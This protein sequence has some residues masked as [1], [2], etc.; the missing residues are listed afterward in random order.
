MPAATTT[1]AAA[2]TERW[3]RSPRLTTTRF[4]GCA[5]V[6][7]RAVSSPLHSG[8]QTLGCFLRFPC[9]VSAAFPFLRRFFSRAIPF[10]DR[11]APAHFP[12]VRHSSPLLATR[13]LYPSLC[14]L[15]IC[16]TPFF[17]PTDAAAPFSLPLPS[18][19]SLAFSLL[20]THSA[21]DRVAHTSVASS[22]VAGHRRCSFCFFLG[23]AFFFLFL[24]SSSLFVSGHPFEFL[25]VYFR[26][27]QTSSVHSSCLLST[28]FERV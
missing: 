18:S 19:L 27:I 10:K 23:L 21:L 6:R 22:A 1:A 2:T 24:L 25:F 20:F 15:R 14:A 12:T 4:G 8:P 11:F 17:S 9:L 26:T 7:A 13:F 3:Y 28:V 16:S 5:S